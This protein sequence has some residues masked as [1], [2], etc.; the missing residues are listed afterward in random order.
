MESMDSMLIV[1]NTTLGPVLELVFA[2]ASLIGVVMAGVGLKQLATAGANR[3]QYSH[4]AGMGATL[5]LCGS[6]LTSLSGSGALVQLMMGSFYGG[7][8]SPEMAISTIP[9]GGASP[10]HDWVR[11]LLNLLVVAGWIAVVRGLMVLG[12]AGSR[13]EKGFGAGVTF[14]VTG[15]L[16]TNPVAFAR[17]IGFTIGRQDIVQILIPGT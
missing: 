14:I 1:N 2:L 10:A 4:G 7:G 13:R 17:M 3:G 8:V 9:G 5:V 15:M 6:L 16:L 12:I 11:V